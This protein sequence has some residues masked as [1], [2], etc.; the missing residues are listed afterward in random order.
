MKTILLIIPDD[1]L[2]RRF[3]KFLEFE[4][5]RVVSSPSGGDALSLL[6]EALR[7]VSLIIASVDT[8]TCSSFESLLEYLPNTRVLLI[9]EESAALLSAPYPHLDRPFLPE[10]LVARVQ[11]MLTATPGSRDLAE[12]G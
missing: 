5:Y 6:G 10:R 1:S 11:Q 2:R 9:G 7:I 4:N 8:R 3:R 12:T